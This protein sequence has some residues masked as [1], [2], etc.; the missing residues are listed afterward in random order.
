MNVGFTKRQKINESYNFIG[1]Y[2]Q[3]G[4]FVAKQWQLAARYDLF[5]RNGTGSDGILNSPAGILNSPAV[6]CNYFIKNTGLKLSA[7]YQFVGRTG[8]KTQ[9]DRDNDD[10]GIAKHSA[11]VM[12]QYTF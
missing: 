6:G 5:N 2:A 9:L 4:Y 3:A 11:I 8:H 1:G 12:M 7:M 10:L